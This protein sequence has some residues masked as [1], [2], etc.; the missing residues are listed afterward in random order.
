ME[1]LEI[2]FRQYITNVRKLKESSANHYVQALRTVSRFLRDKGLIKGDIYS[3]DQLE[4]LCELKDELQKI[5]AFVAQDEIGNRMY[6]A[7]L[8]RYIDFAE[9]RQLKVSKKVKGIDI[10][11]MDVPVEKGCKKIK[12]TYGWN[13]GRVIVEQVLAADKYHCEIDVNHQTFVTRGKGVPYIEGHHLI[14]MSRQGDF[15]KSLD[16]Y[17]NIIGLCPT[18]HRQLH[19]GRRKDVRNI[20]KPLYDLRS[21]RLSKSGINISKE[22]FLSLAVG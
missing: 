1:Q 21:A 20:L 22:E 16:V 2:Y 19:L 10:S 11:L 13:R 15:G 6:S 18:C 9:L 12:I 4:R 8:N 17:A 14:P 5:P 3:E 7:G